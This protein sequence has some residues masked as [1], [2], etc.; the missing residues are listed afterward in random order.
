M[1]N[2]FIPDRKAQLA[3]LL[4]LNRKPDTAYGEEGVSSDVNRITRAATR[5]KKIAENDCNGYHDEAV[6]EREV[7]EGKKLE[8]RILHILSFY[9]D[10]SVSF[11]GDPRGAVVYIKFPDKPGD[12]WGG[13]GYGVFH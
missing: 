2:T 4:F 8:D 9:N 10:V 12:D 7:K 1:S 13:R 11:N 6:R 3:I 5:L